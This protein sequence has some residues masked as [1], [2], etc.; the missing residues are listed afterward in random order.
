MAPVSSAG[1]RST[2]SSFEASDRS[3]PSPPSVLLIFSYSRLTNISNDAQQQ[4][5]FGRRVPDACD[6]YRWVERNGE[7]GACLT[8]SSRRIP[9]SSQLSF[10]QQNEPK[11]TTALLL[12]VLD[13]GQTIIECLKYATTGE[14]PPNTK[15]GAFVHDPK[16]SPSPCLRSQSQ[17]PCL[18]QIRVADGQIP[19]SIFIFDLLRASRL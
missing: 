8:S 14:L 7:N 5:R 11:L 12:L 2:G 13:G 19:A 4:C 17:T 3:S 16:V 9:P 18:P 6:G 1:P 15:G 10:V